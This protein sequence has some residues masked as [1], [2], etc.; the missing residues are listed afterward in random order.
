MPGLTLNTSSALPD[1]QPPPA[2]VHA[3]IC[4]AVIDLGT[5]PTKFI[6]PKTGLPIPKHEV[7]LVFELPFAKMEDG[8]PF[9]VMDKW[10]ASL[11]EKAKLRAILEGWRGQKWPK[12][13]VES[14][15]MK[16]LLGKPGMVDV[17]HT[18]RADGGSWVNINSIT[19]L[20][21]NPETGL[22]IKLPPP[23]NTLKF[24]ELTREGFDAAVFDSLGQKTQE[25]IR[26]SA[27]WP[28]LHSES[29]KTMN[30]EG[31]SDEWPGVD[32]DIPF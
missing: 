7:R 14:F 15:S 5:H 6:S 29:V 17:I 24:L 26:A 31:R 20:G 27:E 21:R 1:F 28:L 19:R 16:D 2:D 3:G 22:P 4:I 12:G 9:V 32:S 8:R 10:N 18:P 13:T 23:V 25:T 11:N 30:D